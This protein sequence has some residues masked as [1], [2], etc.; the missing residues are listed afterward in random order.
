MTFHFENRENDL[1]ETSCITSDDVLNKI[2][3]ATFEKRKM[4]YSDINLLFHSR[5]KSI[6]TELVLKHLKRV[7]G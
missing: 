2:Q 4:I 7:A 1:F 3:Q 6:V 5:M